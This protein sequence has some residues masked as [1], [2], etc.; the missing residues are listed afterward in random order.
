LFW[1]NTNKRLG[2]GHTPSYP[3]AVVGAASSLYAAEIR[4]GSGSGSGGL[5]VTSNDGSVQYGFF[6]ATSAATDIGNQK[7]SSVTNFYA[8]SGSIRMFLDSTGFMQVNGP[9]K[10]GSV[11]FIVGDDGGASGAFLNQ[12]AAQPLRFLTSGAE[13]LRIDANG[14]LTG[15]VLHNP[16]TPPTNTSQTISSG[17][18]S[19][20]LTSLSNIDSTATAVCTWMR[21]GNVVNVCG[22]ISVD[23]TVSSTLTQVGVSLPIASNFTLSTDLKGLGNNLGTPATISCDTTNDRAT[24]TY[25][26]AQIVNSEVIFHFQYLVK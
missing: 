7:A 24:I 20:T 23:A 25:T 8:G 2:I 14:N 19:P 26:T 13:R 3:L 18:Y 22:N 1:D 9:S 5:H 16:S 12:T 17:T 6:S 4:L 21:V 11:N 15:T 10:L